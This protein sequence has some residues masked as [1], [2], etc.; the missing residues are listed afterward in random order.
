MTSITKRVWQIIDE[1]PSIRKDLSRD[2]V[3]VSGLAVYLQKRHGI[4]GS[5][6]SV[7]S[8]IRRYRASPDVREQHTSVEKSFGEMVVGTKT[9]I[10]AIR[11]KNSANL[12]K[13][14]SE[15]MKDDEFYR[16]EIFRLIKSREETLV[17][18]DA[19]SLSRA[20]SFFPEA[21]IISTEKGLAEL[22]LT[23]TKQGWRSSGILA[24]VAN[25]IA[26]YG[27]TIVAVVSVE[28]RISLFVAEK[29]LARAHEAVLSLTRG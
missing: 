14:L 4:A 28:P 23:L 26:N 21:N 8:A 1:D 7:I 5:L 15:L 29:D 25:E 12:Y 3:N 17:M 13:Y 20:K 11:L 6:D 22:S 2:I 18:I 16:N 9:K 27:V 10:T 24:R 19:E